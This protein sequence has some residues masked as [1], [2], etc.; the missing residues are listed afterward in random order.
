[1]TSGIVDSDKKSAHTRTNMVQ[2]ASLLMCRV[3]TESFITSQKSVNLKFKLLDKNQMKLRP[4]SKCLESLAPRANDNILL[5]KHNRQQFQ[6][7]QLLL[8]AQHASTYLYEYVRV[9]VTLRTKE[10]NLACQNKN[11]KNSMHA[12]KDCQTRYA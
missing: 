12:S 2:N 9:R 6:L 4:R 10:T 3:D 1:M 5:N 11:R 7:L 8:T